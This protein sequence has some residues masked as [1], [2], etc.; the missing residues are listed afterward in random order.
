MTQISA[1]RNRLLNQLNQIELGRQHLE[2]EGHK[3]FFSVPST[4]SDEAAAA[5][6]SEVSQVE[7]PVMEPK[8]ETSNDKD[9]YD[10][11]NNDNV[12]TKLGGNEPSSSRLSD[13]SGEPDEQLPAKDGPGKEPSDNDN[14]PGGPMFEIPIIGPSVEDGQLASDQLE[15]FVSSQVPQNKRVLC[16]IVRNK[17]QV[18]LNKSKSYPNPTCYLFVQAIVDLEPANR[19]RSTLTRLNQFRERSIEEQQLRSSISPKLLTG[20]NEQ[21]TYPAAATAAVETGLTGPDQQEDTISISSSL[22]TDLLFFENSARIKSK[23]SK[24]YLNDTNNINEQLHSPNNNDLDD[25]KTDVNSF[26]DNELDDGLMD[27]EQEQDNRT[28]NGQF[29]DV[30]SPTHDATHSNTNETTTSIGQLR[31]S[32]IVYPSDKSSNYHGVESATSSMQWQ[33]GNGSMNREMSPI[34]HSATSIVN[35]IFDNDLNQYTGAVGVVLSAKRRKNAK[36]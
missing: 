13:D 11:N 25:T 9:D 35:D 5:A 3:S 4:T 18:R 6:G 12:D 2:L 10:N 1:K 7:E 29:D 31:D 21:P 33:P 19:T 15:L 22:S 17:S 8:A 26:S 36:T 16:L 24:I 14:H 23:S 28:T 34:N 32:P 20:R 27:G 30:T